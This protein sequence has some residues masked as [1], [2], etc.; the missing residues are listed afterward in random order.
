VWRSFLLNSFGLFTILVVEV[1]SCLRITPCAFL[2]GPATL[3]LSHL[4]VGN[5]ELWSDCRVKCQNTHLLSSSP[6]FD[7]FFTLRR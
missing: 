2:L 4:L 1:F 6:N 5:S 3:P 7:I